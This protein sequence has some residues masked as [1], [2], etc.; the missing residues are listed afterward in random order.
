MSD[1]VIPD[2]QAEM[3][4]YVAENID[5]NKVRDYFG[6]TLKPMQDDDLRKWLQEW[7]LSNG[8]EQLYKWFAEL[9]KGKVETISRITYY[10]LEIPELGITATIQHTHDENTSSDTVEVASVEFDDKIYDDWD[11]DVEDALLSLFDL[12]FP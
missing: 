7:L 2:I 4:K 8:E 1:P 11:S 3:A 6:N 12:L 9:S 10:S 5:L